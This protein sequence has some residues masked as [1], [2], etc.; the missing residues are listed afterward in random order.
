M[1]NSSLGSKVTTAATST[2]I[3]TIAWRKIENAT[4]GLPSHTLNLLHRTLSENEENILIICDYIPSL[5]SEVNLS[6][7]YRK[8]V[9]TLLCRF[10]TFF[11]NVKFFKDITR[12][13]LCC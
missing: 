1:N 10:S 4:E 12:E 9:I 8:D 6:D 13:V 11:N 7:H 3:D 2:T 5:K